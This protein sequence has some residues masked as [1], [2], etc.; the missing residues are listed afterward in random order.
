M[1]HNFGK[2]LLFI[3]AL[4]IAVVPLVSQTNPQKKPSFEVVSIKRS[5]GARK[6]NLQGL[7]DFN[8]QFST[9]GTGAA[10][11]AEENPRPSLFTAVQE[12]LGLRLE[13]TKGPVDVL[14][15]ESVQKPTEN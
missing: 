4:G 13:S 1:K 2:V 8:L 7:F 3:L 6:T 11:P 15:I 10:P 9:V 12:Q 5:S 14:V